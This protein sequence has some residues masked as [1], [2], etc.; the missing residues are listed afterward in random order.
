MSSGP[1]ACVS[2][3]PIVFPLTPTVTVDKSQLAFKDTIPAEALVPHLVGQVFETATPKMK[4]ALVDA[5]LR[6][7]GA[8]SV[9]A[10]AGGVFGR[11]RFHPRWPHLEDDP[12]IVS[13]V[14]SADI[15]A[16]VNHAQQ[17]S[18]AVLDNLARVVDSSPAMTYS[19][20][21]ALLTAILIRRQKQR[22][23]LF[24]D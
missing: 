22:A 18:F 3:S 4:C 16:L 20:A 8:L 13:R 11:I 12:D 23:V 17:V 19:A 2:P 7:L 9:V 5:L 24:E 6:P 21:A 15:V 10:V 14:R 1:R